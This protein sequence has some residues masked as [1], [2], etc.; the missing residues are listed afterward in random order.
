MLTE[1]E[2]R[3]LIEFTNKFFGLDLS[4]NLKPIALSEL[5]KFKKI[6]KIIDLEDFLSHCRYDLQNS[7][8][9]DLL[10]IFLIPHTNFFRNNRQFEAL[11]SE[12][13]P[14]CLANMDHKKIVDL[15][16]WSAGCSTGEEAYSILVSLMEYFGDE[17]WKITCGIMA[18]DIS[19]KSLEIASKGVYETQK[20][21]KF[22]RQRIL[23]YTEQ[24]NDRQLRF[25]EEIRKEANFKQLNLNS[26]TF[27]FKN[28]FHI[29]FCRN[30]LIYLN[31][32]SRVAAENK[33]FKSLEEGGFIFL[34]DAEVLSSRD[35]KF[36]QLG[37]GIYRKRI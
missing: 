19:R 1:K 31:K 14:E 11:K 10:E 13:I 35:H 33:M 15:R 3:A 29:I 30:I 18:T 24:E 28:K 22:I 12:V 32:D 6:N 27:P 7:K 5:N 37:N 8:I 26:K 20:I 2:T 4:E 36:Q 23:E 21:D 34:G 9:L 25:K 17:Y 16:I